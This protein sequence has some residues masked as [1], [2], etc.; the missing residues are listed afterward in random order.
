ML[1][2]AG[3]T[4]EKTQW[5]EFLEAVSTLQWVISFLLLG[6]IQLHLLFT[7]NIMSNDHF[8]YAV[9]SQIHHCVCKTATCLVVLSE[10]I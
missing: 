3:K 5:K 1:Q 7:L 6:K 10:L 9:D 8:C 2:V 4:K